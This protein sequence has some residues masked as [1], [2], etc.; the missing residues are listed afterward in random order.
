MRK[1]AVL[2]LFLLTAGVVAED[3]WIEQIKILMTEQ[4]KADY[5]KLQSDAD[6]QKFVNEFWAKRDPSP[7]TPENEYKNNFEK[8][9]SQVNTLMKDKQ[10]FETDMGQTLLLLGD[11]FEQKEEK[12]DTAPAYGE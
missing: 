2:F 9:L 12:Q 8:N 3:T 11:K 4:E 10:A 1:Y 6:K 7:G 5:K